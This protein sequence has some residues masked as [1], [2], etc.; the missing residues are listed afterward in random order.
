MLTLR[1]E[2]T[3]NLQT[4]ATAAKAK[5]RQREGEALKANEEVERKLQPLGESLGLRECAKGS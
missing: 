2:L 3:N 1:S 4:L 5:Q